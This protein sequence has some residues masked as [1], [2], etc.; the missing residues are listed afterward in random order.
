MHGG[1]WVQMK[2]SGEVSA[3]AGKLAGRAWWGV[4][5]L[6]AFVTAFTFSIQPQVK[7]NFTTWPAGFVFPLL[8]VA[9]IA[10]ALFELGKG[11]ERKAFLASCAYL[12]G[13]LTRGVFGVY[14]V[15]LPA[16]DPLY[17]VT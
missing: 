16:R 8:A 9:G 14:P 11:G 17:F 3:R 15:G 7:E 1:I 6:T 4:V 2:T 10:G 5:G 13:M 12:A